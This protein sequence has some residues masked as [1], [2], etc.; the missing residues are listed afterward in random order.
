MSRKYA[1]GVVKTLGE[2]VEKIDAVIEHELAHNNF[3]AVA[4]MKEMRGRWETKIEEAEK[5]L[6]EDD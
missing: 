4:T 1:E 5:R 2:C 3:E 6:K